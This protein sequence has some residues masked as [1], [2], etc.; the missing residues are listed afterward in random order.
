MMKFTS[1]LA[2][3]S[4]ATLGLSACSGG[5]DSAREEQIEELAR[6]HGVDA[7]VTLGVDGEVEQVA[8]KGLGGGTVGKNLSMPDDFPDDVVVDSSWNIMGTN[9]VP[10]GGHMVQAMSDSEAAAIMD[11]LRPAMT[12]KGWT[13]TDAGQPIG[14]MSKIGFEKEGRMAVYTIITGGP[15]RTVQLVTMKKPG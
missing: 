13:E 14:P 1:L 9:S 6:Q 15:Q 8:V 4:L 10:T 2:T 11:M 3:I 7:D 12:A 5:S